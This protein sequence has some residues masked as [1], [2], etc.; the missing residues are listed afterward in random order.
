MRFF[1][2]GIAVL[3]A[4]L[5][6]VDPA[7]AADGGSAGIAAAAAGIG[8]G[9][10][11]LGGALGQAKV[12]SSALDSIGRNPGASGQMFTPMILGLV[13]VESLVIFALVIA[14]KLAGL[15]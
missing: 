11:S 3:A 6:V 7:F 15:F 2:R 9:I 13:F 8:I 1:T 14:L 12:A 5:A 4:C 10:A